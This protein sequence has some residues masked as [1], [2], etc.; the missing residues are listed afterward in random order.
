MIN[1]SQ[2]IKSLREVIEILKRTLYSTMDGCLLS[3]KFPEEI[4]KNFTISFN[5]NIL[6]LIQDFWNKNNSKL[7]VQIFFY[8]IINIF[9]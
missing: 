4:F 8:M 3:E 2:D 6:L 1:Y 7:Y 5:K 9:Y